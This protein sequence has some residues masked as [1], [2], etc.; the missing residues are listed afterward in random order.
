[1]HARNGWRLAAYNIARLY[2]RR[3]TLAGKGINRLCKQ[4]TFRM[5]AWQW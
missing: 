3:E 2:S 4:Q 1:M 5:G